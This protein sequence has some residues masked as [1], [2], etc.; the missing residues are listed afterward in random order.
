MIKE[1]KDILRVSFHLWAIQR[2]IWDDGVV[3]ISRGY[4]VK[5]NALTSTGSIIA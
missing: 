4:V 1:T 3:D 5:L 2:H